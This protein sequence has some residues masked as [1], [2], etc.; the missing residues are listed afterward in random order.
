MTGLKRGTVH[1]SA[2]DPA[3]ADQARE[4][5]RILWEVF[6]DLAKD[7]QHIGST[8]IPGI[9]A[10]PIIDIAVGVGSFEGLPLKALEAAG[11]QERHNRFSSN[12]LYVLETEDR[13]RTHQV[14][15]L[16]FDSL[17]WH[18]YVDFRDYMNV[19]PEKAAEYEALKRRLV[20]ECGN[21]QMAYT[22]GKH[23]YMEKTLAE[24]RAYASQKSKQN[25]VIHP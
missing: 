12:L 19:F 25:Y 11:F 18:N 1:L 9:E 24:A 13:V 7:I 8:A 2:H 4:T 21:V 10:K 6:G 14:H 5:I 16:L 15:I 17:Q 20:S 22:D 23:D 3:W